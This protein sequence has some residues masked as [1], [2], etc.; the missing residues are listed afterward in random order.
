MVHN[1]IYRNGPLVQQSLHWSS[2]KRDEDTMRMASANQCVSC[3]RLPDGSPVQGEA[4]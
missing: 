2:D 1:H 4:R 3:T